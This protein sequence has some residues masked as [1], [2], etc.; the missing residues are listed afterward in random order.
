[1]NPAGESV[2]RSPLLVG[3]TES[4]GDPVH[5]RALRESKLLDRAKNL[6]F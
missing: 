2:K 4:L 5:A 1:M 6:S 3:W